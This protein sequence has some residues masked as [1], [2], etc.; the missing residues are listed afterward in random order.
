MQE[1]TNEVTKKQAELAIVKVKD[2]AFLR[3][4]LPLIQS[5]LP[6]KCILRLEKKDPSSKLEKESFLN[7]YALKNDQTV[8]LA[9]QYIKNAKASFDEM[10]R[11][12]LY[13]EFTKAG[14]DHWTKMTTKNTGKKI[15]IVFD[16]AVLSAPLVMGPI[17]GGSTVLSGHFTLE[18]TKRLAAIFMSGYLPLNLELISMNVENVK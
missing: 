15:A 1:P 16:D 3:Q 4:C 6:A 18:E 12:N 14:R 10:R 5:L 7:L 17:T 8:M 9:N 13:I 2:T 11:P